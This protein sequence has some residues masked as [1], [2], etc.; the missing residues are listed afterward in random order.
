MQL[1]PRARPS[2]RAA[3][4]AGR[5]AE[6]AAT[7]R[8]PASFLEKYVEPPATSRCR[9]SAT[10]AAACWRS[11]SATARCSGATRR[12][13]EETPAPRPAGGDARGGCA[14]PRCGSAQAVALS[15]GRHGRVRLRRATREPSTSSRST[16]PAGRARR[17][18]G[19]DRRRPGRV[20]GAPGGRRAAAARRDRA[21]AARR[22][23]SRC[24]STPRI[25][26]KDFQPSAG[27]LTEVGFPARRARRRLG[28]A[29]HRGDA[30]TTTRCSPSS[31]CTA[32]TATRRWRDCATAL[33][34]HAHR[35]HRDQPR[36]PARDRSPTPAVRAG[37]RQHTRY[38]DASALRAVA[39]SRCSSRARRPP[40]RTIPAG[41][42]TGTSACRRR[43][44]WTR[45][46]FGSPTALRRQPPTARR[47][48]SA[49]VPGP[50]LRFNRD[51]VDLRSTGADM[52]ADAR[53]RAGAA[54][55]TPLDVARRQRAA[56]RARSRGA[57]LRAYLAVR[58]GFDVPDY[59]GSRATFTLGRFGGHAGRA[60]RAGDVLHLATPA[61]AAARRRRRCRRR[62]VPALTPRL[63]DRRARTARTA[64]PTSSPPT[65]SR[66]FFATDWRGALQ[67]EPHRRA[68]DR[69][70]AAVG[71]RRRRRG[72]AASVEHPRQR[73][74]R[75]HHRLH[76]R[77]A[78]H[79]RPR[80]PEPGRL[81]LPGDDRRRPSCGRSASSSPAT[82]VRF[83]PVDA[84]RGARR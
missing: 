39:R 25:R 71:A 27:L 11:A 63:G 73:L 77:H 16:P 22:R 2:W 1:L 21:G 83:V 7:S 49:R 69:P 44:R 32:T 66:R 33:A 81:R 10:A 55:G 46:R 79:P 75:R 8:T 80:R 31:S 9:S 57:G 36:L 62:C 72:R 15:L 53:R 38:L 64:R 14:T 74:R 12:S 68:P 52:R 6:P 28:R 60:L 67:L 58:G 18:R 35:R 4:A 26:R 78:D 13:I 43:G 61:D 50:T 70:E 40:C 84:R 42:A 37:R 45:C 65:T 30:V 47:R 29:R 59:L 48:W 51:A 54:S 23:R 82:R 20:D 17:H 24:G 56:A 76:R 41:S 5:A 34:A 19:G 3:F